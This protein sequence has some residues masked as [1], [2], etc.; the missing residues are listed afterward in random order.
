MPY[1]EL[2]EILK[3]FEKKSAA[4]LLQSICEMKVQ[5][6][7]SLL[8][9]LFKSAH[10]EHFKERS[11]FNFYSNSTFAGEPY[12]FDSIESRLAYVDNLIRFAALYAD[13]VIIPSPID[14]VYFEYEAT[15]EID[16]REL[17]FRIAIL[18]K[19]KPLV[20][21]NIIGFTSRVFCACPE[22]MKMV[23]SSG[24]AAI[25]QINQIASY[26][27]DDVNNNVTC[28][29]HQETTGR[30][31]LIVD[32]AQK[33]GFD[34]RLAIGF[35]KEVPLLSSLLVSNSSNDVVLT[36]E[37]MKNLGFW[38]LLL[39]PALDDIISAQVMT[40]IT[41]STYLTNRPFDVEIIGAIK[42]KANDILNANKLLESL[43]HLVPIIQD[44]DIN[45]IIK[46]RNSEGEAFIVYRD[47]INQ[48]LK[49]TAGGNLR[50]AQEY[51]RE[52]I[53]PELNKI[54]QTIS[55]NKKMLLKKTAIDISIAAAAISIGVLSGIPIDYATL[56]TII[57]GAPMISGIVNDISKAYTNSNAKDN[58]YYFLWQLQKSK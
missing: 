7:E 28:T 50:I 20:L 37:T 11:F 21:A 45:N 38:S 57:G 17:A 43:Y 58:N 10:I 39:E 23:T 53:D 18:F 12:P 42:Q 13:K 32:N 36:S 1:K 47:S 49:K 52:M 3:P 22:C 56:A 25:E 40:E 8:E 15:K 41:N 26:I 54:A 4:E 2:Y 14:N 6:I 48:A 34:D 5:K 33:Y 31:L 19:L 30:T 27:E 44:A 9:R 24:E 51:K 35:S 16:R 29:V 46:L 55:N